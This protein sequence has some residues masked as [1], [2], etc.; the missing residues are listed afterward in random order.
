MG[1]PR[2]SVGRASGALVH[3]AE[4]EHSAVR[5]PVSRLIPPTTPPLILRYSY[6]RRV[7]PIARIDSL[8]KSR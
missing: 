3:S 8:H 2:I 1:M 6:Q 4:T 5:P 7:S